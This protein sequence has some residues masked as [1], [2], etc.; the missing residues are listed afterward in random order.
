[1]YHSQLCAVVDYSGEDSLGSDNGI[2]FKLCGRGEALA[3]ESLNLSATKFLRHWLLARCA[4]W[5]QLNSATDWRALNQTDK[6]S[7]GNRSHVVVPSRGEQRSRAVKWQRD[8]IATR[9]NE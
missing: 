3:E 4:G 8:L 2:R 1:M 5:R 6:R 7:A 9:M